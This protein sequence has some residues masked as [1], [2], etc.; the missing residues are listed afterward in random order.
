LLKDVFDIKRCLISRIWGHNWME[1]WGICFRVVNWGSV[2]LRKNWWFS[3]TRKTEWMCLEWE[4]YAMKLWNWLKSNLGAWD[5]VHRCYEE[6]WVPGI[7]GIAC[8]HSVCRQAPYQC[9][10]LGEFMVLWWLGGSWWSSD[11][12]ILKRLEVL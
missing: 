5:K 2:I 1:Q 8:R 4:P 6:F 11:L 10:E 7:K 12:R 9:C 3:C